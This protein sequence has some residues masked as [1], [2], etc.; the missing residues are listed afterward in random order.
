[1]QLVD[2]HANL[3]LAQLAQALRQL[4]RGAARSENRS[5]SAA[6]SEKFPAAMIPTP[7]R[8]AAASSSP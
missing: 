2:R 1:V 8:R 6:V 7:F 5:N 3:R 4:A